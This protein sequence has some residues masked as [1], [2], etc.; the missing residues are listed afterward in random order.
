M[1]RITKPVCSYMD[2]TEKTDL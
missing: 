2:P 1:H